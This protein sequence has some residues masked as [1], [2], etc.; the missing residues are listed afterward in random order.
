MS[1]ELYCG[2]IT[3]NYSPIFLGVLSE[4]LDA[5]DAQMPCLLRLCV[6]HYFCYCNSSVGSLM[7][8]HYIFSCRWTSVKKLIVKN[9]SFE[10]FILLR[11]IFI[12]FLK[13]N[14]VVHG[15]WFNPF[16]SKLRFLSQ[17][18]DMPILMGIIG[19]NPTPGCS[20]LIILWNFGPP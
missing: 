18:S 11:F 19:Q 13:I 3:W 12:K 7:N 20:Y 14:T 4:D 16:V 15:D 5:K 17:M 6:Y 8:V 1:W 2:G 9:N 10:R